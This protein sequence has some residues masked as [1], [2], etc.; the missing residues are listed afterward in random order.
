MASRVLAEDELENALQHQIV[1]RGD[2]EEV[3]LCKKPRR[4][5]N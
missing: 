5:K 2:D 1:I 3:S 4:R